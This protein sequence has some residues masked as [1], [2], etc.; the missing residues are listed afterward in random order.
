L[1][2]A[3]Y[4]LAL[5]AVALT[6]TG[7]LLI[8]YPSKTFMLLLAGLIVASGMAVTAGLGLTPQME[9]LRVQ[10]KQHTTEFQKYHGKAMITMVVESASLLLSGF[11][12][13]AAVGPGSKNLVIETSP[14]DPE[15]VPMFDK[16]KR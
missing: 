4:E 12:L 10:G 8:T 5:A 15:Y 16:P 9:A 13:L 6:G 3:K 2:F 7:L 11:V 14:T 1:V